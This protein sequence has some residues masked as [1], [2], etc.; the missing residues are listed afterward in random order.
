MRLVRLRRLVRSRGATAL[1]A[2]LGI[3]AAYLSGL[4]DSGRKASTIGRRAAAIGYH[5]KMA[6]HQPPTKQEGVRAVLR[7]I[8]RTIGAAKQGKAPA[9]A[10]VLKPDARAVPGQRSPASGRSDRSSG[11]TQAWAWASQ[12]AASAVAMRARRPSRTA[13][14]AAAARASSRASASVASHSGTS[15]P[16]SAVPDSQVSG[17]GDGAGPIA[18]LGR[19][20][21]RPVG[22]GFVRGVLPGRAE[23]VG[24]VVDIA[25]RAFS[26]HQCAS[27]NH[28]YRWASMT[29]LRRFRARWIRHFGGF[30]RPGRT[31]SRT[32]ENGR[33]EF[34]PII[35]LCGRRTDVLVCPP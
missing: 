20:V 9:T 15:R 27:P 19:Q 7:G 35:L 4:A 16:A 29:G 2:H 13:S 5:H 24:I 28:W 23:Q 32:R 33:K 8:R 1:P 26:R 10:D 17:P 30:R 12:P 34:R 21:P 18:G 31:C 14:G 3:V 6:G 22:V 25:E 11:W